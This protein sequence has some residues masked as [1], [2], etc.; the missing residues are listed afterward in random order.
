MGRIDEALRRA[1]EEHHEGLPTPTESATSD[2]F[3]APWSFDAKEDSL[4]VP[5]PANTIR[6]IS[7]PALGPRG[8]LEFD[9]ELAECLVVGPRCNPVLV[10]QYRRLA[11]KLHNAQAAEGIR[12]ILITSA[13][14]GDGKSLS[15]ANLA[16]TLSESYRRRVL[17]VDGDLRRPSLHE[18]FR[19]PNDRGLNEGLSD[20]G[21]VQLPARA[22]TPTLTLLP[23]GRPKD[24]PMSLLASP[25]MHYLLRDASAAFDWVVLDTAPVGLLA[26][27][28]VLARMAEKILLVVRAGVTP[29]AMVTQTLETL[30]REKI[31]GVLLNGVT[32]DLATGS[33]YY[34]SYAAAPPTQSCRPTA[35]SMATLAG[36]TLR[37]WSLLAVDNLL[38]VGGL[39]T[40]VIIRLGA[41]AS[42]ITWAYLWRVL[43]I[44]G[45]FQISLHYC[46]LYEPGRL[47]DRNHLLVKL[48]QA[49]A[50]TSLIL[51]ILYYWLPAT[52]I[53]RGIVLMG[54]LVVVAL[55]AGWR[56]AFDVFSTSV[57]AERLLIVGMSQAS[58]ELARELSHR[59]P[60]LG[61]EIVG[62]VDVEPNERRTSAGPAEI[63]GRISDIPRI[64]SERR[65]DRVIVSL[66]DARGKLSMDQLLDMK[67]HDGV[68]FDHLASVYE[69]FTG[70]IAVEN[71]RP[72]WLIFSEGFR[73]SP[74]L[75]GAKR[76]V[77]LVCALIGIVLTGPIMLLVACAVKLSSP[78]PAIYSQRRVGLNG[79]VFTVHKFRSMR[80]DAESATGAVW[81]TQ[82][83]P[84]V[85]PVGRFLRR[86]RLDELPQFWNV[87]HGD[88]SL[89]GP[90]PER[91][92]FVAELTKSIPYYGQ[93]HVVR[94]GVT[95][96]AQIRHGYTASVEDALQKL[97]YDLFYVKN[98]SLTLDTFIVAETLKTVL[99]RRGS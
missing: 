39:T 59:G 17:L 73:K 16:L 55:V 28:H 13:L 53:G 97:Q 85:T 64:A 86:T 36:L 41:S 50:A 19:V 48:F 32:Q 79:R 26:D 95:G 47:R 23:A 77:D 56:F 65:V 57:G 20:E 15:A 18:I 24:D 22:L 8:V 89:V 54:G 76:A 99:V 84:R 75:S 87:L 61:V 94:P 4:G 6:T 10:E 72:S 9:P 29:H 12:V 1:A 38:I 43:L 90:R 14:P 78:G 82:N 80:A 63:I 30:G 67:L 74:L 83:D 2:V 68:R 88:M 81:A 3:V 91:P 46:D 21:N 11:A 71:L 49:F 66:A 33:V 44:A 96:W 69:E 58:V 25:R 35:S 37:R 93:R 42:L 34:H 92:E 98:M 70:R 27:G 5:R 7:P 60:D 31:L 40:A 51:A 52:T 45:V 62:F